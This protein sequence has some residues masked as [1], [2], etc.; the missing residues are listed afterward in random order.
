MEFNR[1]SQRLTVIVTIVLGLI[2]AVVLG[3]LAGQERLGPILMVVLGG[4]ALATLLVLKER[5]WIVILFAWPMTGQI[6]ALNIPFSVRDLVVMYVFVGYLALIAFKII[7]TRNRM[8]LIDLFMMSVLLMLAIAFIRN[9]VGF[10]ALGS[11]R[12]GGRPYFNILIAVIAWW[13]LSRSDLASVSP[14]WTFVAVLLGRCTDGFLATTLY[15]IPGLEG[16]FAEFYSSPVMSSGAQED[17][18]ASVLSESTERLS[19]LASLVMPL[20]LSLF[21]L[22]RPLAWVNILKPWKGL[23]F[24]FLVYMLMKSGFRS[25]LVILTA[26]A[27][28]SGY[29]RSG[30]GEVLKMIGMGILAVLFAATFQNVLFNLPKSI[31][32]TLSVLPGSWDPVAVSEGKESTEWRVF[33]WK[34]ALFTDRYIENKLLGDGFGIKKTDYA[35]MSYFAQH[36]TME[37]ARENLMIVGNFHSGP[38][39]TIRYV[40]YLGCALYLAMIILLAREGWR[41]CRALKGSS[42]ESLC[43]LMCLTTIVEPFT[44]V[45]VFGSFDVAMPEAV[46]GIGALKL[47]RTAVR[48]KLE[49]K[50]RKPVTRSFD[51]RHPLKSE[52]PSRLAL[53]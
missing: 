17:A 48:E 29:L 19:F 35:I 9:P 18:A 38:V 13:V 47:M 44:Y 3:K 5:V 41:L 23:L 27:M 50:E 49:T 52:T 51:E 16:F 8:T 28:V 6:R 33:M 32:R 10:E 22:D 15:Y 4:A 26:L 1:F 25:A 11:E 45:F 30:R 24:A 40:G 21:A 31:Q 37:D 7:R 43:F 53:R 46:F 12:V 36:G 2:S 14:K 39:T 20:L 42:Y 34:Q